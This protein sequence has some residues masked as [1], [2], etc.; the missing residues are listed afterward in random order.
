VGMI[1][2]YADSQQ[3]CSDEHLNVKS[4]VSITNRSLPSITYHAYERQSF[5]TSDP[6]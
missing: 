3:A 5:D 6:I 1:A 4:L 2:L